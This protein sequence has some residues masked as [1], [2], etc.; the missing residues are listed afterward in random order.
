M[1]S[2]DSCLI[3]S[4]SIV[5]ATIHPDHNNSSN[6]TISTNLKSKG[7]IISLMN[8]HYP[9]LGNTVAGCCCIIPTV[10]S[11][12]ASTVKPLQL[13]RPPLVPPHTLG[14]F[15]WDPFNSKEYAILLACDNS[16]FAKQDTCLQA[17]TPSIKLDEVAG[18]LVRYHLHCP[19]ADALVTLRFSQ[20]VMPGFERLPQPQHLS[21]LLRY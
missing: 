8:V 18:I 15:I 20:W 21:T 14:E 1:I 5:I 13:K 4:L 7:W 10:Y 3:C 11:S 2:S 12:C 16:N 6:K 19:N 17:L 9:D